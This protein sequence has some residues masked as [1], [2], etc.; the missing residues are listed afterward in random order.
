[1]RV[2]EA[3]AATGETFPWSV[4]RG[5]L[6]AQGTWDGATLTLEKTCDDGTTW[7]PICAATTLTASGVGDFDLSS[8]T[9]RAAVSSAGGSTSLTAWADRRA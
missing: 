1:M 5:Q 6:T 7:V 4:G 3:A 2:L 8:C 9:I